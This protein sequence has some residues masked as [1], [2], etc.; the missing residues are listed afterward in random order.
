MSVQVLCPN[1]R[2]QNV[3]VTPNTK[4][5]QV[6]EDVCHKQKFLPPEDYK[7]VY[8]RK[9]LDVTLAVR[10]ANLP[11]NA[12]LELVRSEQSRTESEVVI[13]LQLENG[14][15][16]QHSFSPG[17]TL[18]DMLLY[19]EN[20]R[21]SPFGTVL[22]CTDS[23]QA[24]SMQPVCI[25]MRE[26]FIGEE[27]LKETQLRY[28]GLMGGKALIRLT[29][30]PVE[31]D[32]LAEISTKLHKDRQ[33]R[34]HVQTATAKQEFS[35]MLYE[36]TLAHQQMAGSDSC[37]AT[38]AESDL[39]QQHRD[40]DKAKE[41]VT[42]HENQILKDSHENVPADTMRSETM[43]GKAQ[44]EAHFSAE[45]ME[46]YPNSQMFATGQP[47]ESEDG[48]AQQ[49]SSASDKTSVSLR[50]QSQR[51]AAE[52]LRSL[53]IP[54]VEIFT[55]DDFDVLSQEEQQ[56]CDRQTV[57]FNLEDEKLNLEDENESVS[58]SCGDLGDEFY[59]VTERDLRSLMAD[60]KKKLATF[61]NQ[62]L[63]TSSFRKVK[64]EAEYSHYTHVIIRVHF[65][66]KLVLQGLFRPIETVFALRNFVREHLEDK[67]CQ[68][69]LYTS[70]PKQV[71]T[72][73]S[74]NFIEAKLVPATVV[75]FLSEEFKDHYLSNTV[76]S[77]ISTRA[78]ADLIVSECLS[79]PAETQV[80]QS[81]K[82][83]TSSSS[84]EKVPKLPTKL[85]S[86][87]K[88]KPDTKLV[89]KWFKTSK[90]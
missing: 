7:L 41:A 36:T 1:G 38:A 85:S 27:C 15:R 34:S 14:E 30:R 4:L 61:E 8:G 45:P 11:N 75:Y 74:Q 58:S 62:P 49:K 35:S 26:E 68:F 33:R 64:L 32:V 47:K 59:D 86:N 60:Q 2:R 89:P 71:L 73:A 66:D 67:S 43:N 53:Q 16:L 22:K 20:A 3:K 50:R 88:D 25:Y 28:L 46:I 9:T 72:D 70:P 78:A 39:K 12:K 90:K 82:Q 65:P 6:L 24:P 83:P 42:T 87:N 57:L 37:F 84:K 80:G 76:L 69:C 51:E 10:Y 56:P 31:D 21:V 23:A 77:E 17:I 18:W 63:T 55:P 13:A 52:R 5:L 81:N 40:I 79:S 19:W 29:H 54:G 44:S 48:D